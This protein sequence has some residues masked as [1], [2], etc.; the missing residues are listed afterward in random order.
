MKIFVRLTAPFIG[1]KFVPLLYDIRYKKVLKILGPAI[2]EVNVF[3]C[4]AEVLMDGIRLWT[5]LGTLL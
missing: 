2:K 4:L 5:Y 1:I 3:G